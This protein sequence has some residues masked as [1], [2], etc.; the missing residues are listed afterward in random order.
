VTNTNLP[1]ILHRFQ[2]IA[3]GIAIFGYP[4]CLTLLMEGFP[5][6]DLRKNFCGCPRMARVPNAV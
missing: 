2:D 3:F 4:K 1:P 5:W 6:D